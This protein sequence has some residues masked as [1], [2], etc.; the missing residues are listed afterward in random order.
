M[1]G[2]TED[3]QHYRDLGYTLDL[4]ST[5]FTGRKTIST[6]NGW[7][8]WISKAMVWAATN[9]DFSDLDEC[10]RLLTGQMSEIFPVPC[11][12]AQLA[13]NFVGTPND[14]YLQAPASPNL[15]DKDEICVG[16]QAIIRIIKM[17]GHA[18]IELEI[19]RNVKMSAKEKKEL[20]RKE[21]KPQADFK[22]LEQQNNWEKALST[23]MFA[24][25]CIS[26]FTHREGLVLQ[27][28]RTFSSK[29]F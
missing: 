27:S 16:G 6:T 3:P 8:Y 25:T 29:K 22:S 13:E 15:V 18:E 17:D 12:F 24:Y 9:N 19:S 11:Q 21:F 2:P 7:C 5:R 26:N 1:S 4:T 10:T 23:I 14:E 28:S 20:K